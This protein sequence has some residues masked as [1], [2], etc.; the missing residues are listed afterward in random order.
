MDYKK[1]LQEIYEMGSVYITIL[2][3]D[4]E[5]YND[6]KIIGRA[7]DYE[8]NIQLSF[9]NDSVLLIRKSQIETVRYDPEKI[10]ITLSDGGEIII[11]N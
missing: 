9:T 6:H 8:K 11:E 5:I 10:T 4:L 2:N 7:D 3:D 1:L